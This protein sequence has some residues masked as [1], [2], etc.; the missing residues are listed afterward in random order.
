ML[1]FCYYAASYCWWGLSRQHYTLSHNTRVSRFA[2]PPFKSTERLKL[3]DKILFCSREQSTTKS[4]SASWENP[5]IPGTL[6]TGSCSGHSLL[7]IV[8]N[9]TEVRRQREQWALTSISF[10]RIYLYGPRKR[11]T[12]K[13]IQCI[14]CFQEVPNR[15][16][17]LSS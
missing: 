7:G 3:K 12:D 17:K 14:R 2:P 6:K 5:L 15:I 8:H 10:V 9:R 16:R 4:R 1:G 13:Y 11:Q